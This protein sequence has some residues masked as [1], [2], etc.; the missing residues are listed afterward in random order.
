LGQWRKAGFRKAEVPLTLSLPL[1]ALTF[2]PNGSG[3]AAEFEVRL[4]VEDEAFRRADIPVL[5]F[6][7]EG[8][9]V[10]GPDDRW[11]YT[12]P[13]RLR[14]Q[15]HRGLIALYDVVSGRIFSSDIV[16]EP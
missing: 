2:V 8:T 13:L 3:V 6:R 11:E 4:A 5:P 7:L 14:R 12:L 15:S 1:S 9:E 10:P 16:I